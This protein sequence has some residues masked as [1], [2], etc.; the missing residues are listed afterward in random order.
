MAELKRTKLVLR[1]NIG[2]EE[3]PK[4]KDVTF[5]R[6][7][8]EATDDAVKIVG[9]ALAGLYENTIADS[10]KYPLVINVLSLIRVST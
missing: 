6:V 7:A 8:E 5:T 4:Y 2:T 10:T 1:F 9:T 3:K